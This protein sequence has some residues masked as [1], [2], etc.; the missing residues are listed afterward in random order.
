MLICYG[1]ND[2][3]VEKETALAPLDFIEAEVTPFPKGHVAIA[4]SWSS[5]DSAY[6]LHARYEDGKYRGPVRFHMDMDDAFGK[7]GTP[8]TK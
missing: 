6:A 2:D 4:T 7:K 8:K 3:L 1:T 5:P